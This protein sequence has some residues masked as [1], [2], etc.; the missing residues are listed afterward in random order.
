MKGEAGFSLQ[1]HAW[2]SI[3]AKTG[4]VGKEKGG[5]ICPG[6]GTSPQRAR[7][8]N[9]PHLLSIGFGC[10][11]RKA[12][13]RFGSFS[14]DRPAPDALGMSLRSDRVRTFAPQQFD[15]VCQKPIAFTLHAIAL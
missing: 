11:R 8:P 6:L 14:S 3:E 4:G 15:A 1:E 7:L 2:R 10:S 5:A 13:D 12:F 9:V